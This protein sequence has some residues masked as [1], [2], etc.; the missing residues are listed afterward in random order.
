MEIHARRVGLAAIPGVLALALGAILVRSALWTSLGVPTTGAHFG[1]LRVILLASECAQHESD[2]STASTA[3][4]PGMAIYNYP[5]LWAR[6]F[7]ILGIT[8]DS[9]S[10][11]A[12]FFIILFALAVSALTF[13]SLTSGNS[14]FPTLLMSLAAVS[15]PVLLAFERGN[16]D[17]VIFTLTAVSILL[18]VTSRQRSSAVVLGLAT[19]LKLFPVGSIL[20][21]LTATRRKTS[22]LITYAI[23]TT[24]GLLL[25]VRDLPIIYTRTPALDGASFGSA[26][27]PLLALNH[28]GLPGQAALAKALG[29]GFFAAVTIAMLMVS[30]GK[31]DHLRLSTLADQLSANLVA[32]AMVLAGGGSFLVAYMIGPSFDYRLITLIPLISGLAR[33]GT[34]LARLAAIAVLLQML[35]SYSTFIGAAEYLSDLML[36]LIAPGLA[37]VLWKSIQSHSA[38]TRVMN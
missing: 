28:A 12:F 36:L 35:L 29:I 38:A 13:L 18:F 9:A 21:L 20:M 30:R 2:W 16:I 14:W 7:A 6:L 37:V 5:S 3:C 27:L 31:R 8:A 10:A 24:V 26:V 17:L 22:T 11:V 4:N 34:S 1:D 32:T 25:V 19:F 23:T 33:V 15:P